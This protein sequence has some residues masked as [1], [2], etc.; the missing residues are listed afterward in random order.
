MTDPILDAFLQDA[1]DIADLQWDDTHKI[2]RSMITQRMYEAYRL[3]GLRAHALGRDPDVTRQAI[4]VLRA[5]ICDPTGDIHTSGL[6]DNPETRRA[7]SILIYGHQ[8]Q[9][10][11]ARS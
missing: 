9:R 8:T 6:R 7:L 4:D 3:A 5:N 10:R 1:K 11:G 2:F